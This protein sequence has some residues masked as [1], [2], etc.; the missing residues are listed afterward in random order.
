V[1]NSPEPGT[2]LVHNTFSGGFVTLPDDTLAV[3]RKVDAGGELDATERELIDPELFD[4][5]V[6]VLVESR[7]AEEREFRAW[8]EKQ[9]SSPDRL[10]VILST[11]FACNFDCTYCCQADVLDGR[12]MKA[13]LGE[14]TARW[15]ALRAR[16]IGSKALHIDFVGGE[17]LLHPERIDQIVA[18]IR[19]L[20]PELAI[21]FSLITNGLFLTDELVDR[22]VPLGLVHAQVTLDGDETTHGHTRRSKKKGEDTFAPVFENLVRASHKIS[23]TVNGNYQLDTVHGFVPLIHKLRDAGLKPGSRMRF[24]P[25]LTGLGAP[26]DAASG[27]CLWSGS[28]PEL[29]LPLAA[30]IWK[31]G[32][33]N[34]DPVSIGPCAFHEKHHYAIDPEGHIY[35]CP[36]F[37]GKTEWAIGH[38]TTGLTSRYERLA[39]VN[40]QRGCGSCAHRP[41]CA[42]GCVAAAWVESGRVEGV[43][44]EI[45]FFETYGPELV[46]RKFALATAANPVEA[47]ERFPRNDIEIPTAPARTARRSTKLTV[48]AAA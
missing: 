38:V 27:S 23:V 21:T 11:T 20:A 17:P 45:G 35:K 28:N 48:I 33:D 2:T 19:A 44:C 40:P 7:S 47:V 42:G 13:P 26:S 5:D 10:S 1:A 31:N 46:Q 4:P 30:E 22:W 43:N 39:N 34:G 18:D 15:L 14:A 3:L 16:E 29:M 24:T 9:R 12:T 8:F 6:G 37:L 36:G 32:F 25:A 41:S